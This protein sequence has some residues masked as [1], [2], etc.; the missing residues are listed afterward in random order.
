ME[1]VLEEAISFTAP[2]AAALDGGLLG[3]PMS[4]LLLGGLFVGI[5]A[6]ALF[7]GKKRM[8]AVLFSI[9]FAGFLYAVFPYREKE[10]LFLWEGNYSDL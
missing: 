2:F 9:I 10:K 1:S 8:L 3:V 6:L 5:F 4:A 7:L